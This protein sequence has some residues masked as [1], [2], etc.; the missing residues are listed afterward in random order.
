MSKAEEIL[1]QL[2]EQIVDLARF[3][4]TENLSILDSLDDS[5]NSKTYPL[6]GEILSDD[7]A[8]I[9]K[10]GW[11]FIKSKNVRS[12]ARKSNAIARYL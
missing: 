10:S 11:I 12:L 5:L 8:I 1:Q 7:S 9:G 2:Q 3:N 4:H 6:L